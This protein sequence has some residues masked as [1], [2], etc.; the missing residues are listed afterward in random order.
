MR[1]AV[2]AVGRLKAGPER[3][4]AARYAE[5]LAGAGRGVGLDWRGVAEL[6]E[7]R[8]ASAG[9]RMRA[10]AD[11]LAGRLAPGALWALDERGDM[12]D[13]EA[14]AAGIARLRDGGTPALTLAIGGPDGHGPALRERADAV[15]AL[16]R[17]T[18]P[19]QI[20]RALALEQLYR[21]ATILAGHPYHR[22]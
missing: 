21:A 4:L 8:G 14:F 9:E 1:L 11:A 2:I 5:R 10:E 22:G 18:W 13:S 17:L 12:P 15:I 7:A 6:P 16:G 3:E 20:V 19:H